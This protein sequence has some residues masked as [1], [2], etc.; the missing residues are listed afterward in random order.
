[1]LV[2][3]AY[4]VLK[5]GTIGL[6]PTQPANRLAFGPS[7]MIKGKLSQPETGLLVQQPSVFENVVKFTLYSRLLELRIQL[8]SKWRAGPTCAAAPPDRHPPN[9]A[10]GDH[11]PDVVVGDDDNIAFPALVRSPAMA[12]ATHRGTVSQRKWGGGQICRNRPVCCK[13]S[14]IP[15]NMGHHHL[16]HKGPSHRIAI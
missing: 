3:K 11:V 13:M 1:M 7:Q 12:M 14:E 6:S 5:F 15:F 2:K 16:S 9:G 10:A 4:L 8:L